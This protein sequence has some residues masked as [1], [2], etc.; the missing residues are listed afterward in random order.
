M[1]LA[2]CNKPD[3]VLAARPI[4]CPAGAG[5]PSIPRQFFSFPMF[6]FSPEVSDVTLTGKIVILEGLNRDGSLIEDHILL[7]QVPQ[8]QHCRTLASLDSGLESFQ[9]DV[10]VSAFRFRD[11]DGLAVLRTLKTRGLQTP[12]IFVDQPIGEETVVRAF[13]QGAFD[14]ILRDRLGSLADE[15]S[16]AMASSRARVSRPPDATFLRGDQLLATVSHEIAN[17]LTGIGAFTDV[18]RRTSREPA[19]LGAVDQ[20]KRSLSRGRSITDQILRSSRPA[21]LP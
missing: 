8:F 13:R 14:F 10:V 7:E 20:I 9:P 4:T 1:S 5:L 6:A 19:V 17:V 15:V 12:V 11:F 2:V 3:D 16:R 21:P 18:I